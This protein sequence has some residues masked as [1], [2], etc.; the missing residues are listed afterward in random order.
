MIV[1]SVVNVLVNV[2]VMCAVGNVVMVVNMVVCVVGRKRLETVVEIGLV[3]HVSSRFVVV[4]L[5]PAF[6]VCVLWTSF[7]TA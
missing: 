4:G 7:S 5:C 2:V 1:G 6:L 3:G